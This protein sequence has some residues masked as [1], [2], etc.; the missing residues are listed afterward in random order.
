VV[1]VAVAA[2]LPLPMMS[3]PIGRCPWRRIQLTTAAPHIPIPIIPMPERP[4]TPEGPD[5]RAPRAK[6]QGPQ[7]PRRQ[8]QARNNNHCGLRAARGTRRLRLRLLPELL[9]RRSQPCDSTPAL[10]V[11]VAASK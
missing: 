5:P 10:R 9:L 8:R 2:P 4:P 7:E 3:L 6:G 11:A 1:V